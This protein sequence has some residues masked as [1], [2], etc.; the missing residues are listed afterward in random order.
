MP[1][2]PVAI[3]WVYLPKG[4]RKRKLLLQ[5][6]RAASGRMSGGSGARAGVVAKSGQG[7]DAALRAADAGPVSVTQGAGI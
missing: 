1:N 2:P 3:D 7:G 6:H 5:L 4:L